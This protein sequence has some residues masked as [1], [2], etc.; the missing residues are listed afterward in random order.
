MG[1]CRFNYD[2]VGFAGAQAPKRTHAVGLKTQKNLKLYGG[3]YMTSHVSLALAV[4][5][6]GTGPHRI[7]LM[8]TFAGEV[9]APLFLLTGTLLP[10]PSEDVLKGCPDDAVYAMGGGTLSRHRVCLTLYV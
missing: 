5:V 4:N 6:V 3:D 7:A 9:V 10:P 8:S 2:E 1:V